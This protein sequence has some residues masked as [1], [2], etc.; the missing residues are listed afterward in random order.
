[1]AFMATIECFEIEELATK[2]IPNVSPTLID[3][4]KYGHPYFF[5]LAQQFTRLV[6]DQAFKAIELFVGK[7]EKHAATMV[8]LRSLFQNTCG[9]RRVAR[10]AIP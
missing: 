1:M 10:S 5:F 6:R 9:S 8:S 3:T 4:D 2:V 7:L